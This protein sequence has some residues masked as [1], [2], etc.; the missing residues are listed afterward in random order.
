MD[1][2]RQDIEIVGATEEDA[3]DKDRWKTIIPCGNSIW[4]KGQ[5]KRNMFHTNVSIG[6]F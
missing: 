1:V 3:E 5:I 6:K 4:N 2:V